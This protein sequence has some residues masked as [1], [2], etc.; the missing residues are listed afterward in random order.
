MLRQQLPL[1][2]FAL[3][4]QSENC[5]TLERA[6]RTNLPTVAADFTS[7]HRSHICSISTGKEKS[8]QLPTFRSQADPRSTS[9]TLELPKISSI[10]GCQSHG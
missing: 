7:K 2:R 8:L 9:E 4:Q 1:V 6:V 3:L 10:T 5:A